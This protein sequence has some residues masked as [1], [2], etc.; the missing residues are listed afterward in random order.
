MVKDCLEKQ[1][2]KNL[3]HYKDLVPIPPLG[4]VD[5]LLTVTRC[6][7]Q[8]A[9]MNKFINDKA[10]TKKL[11]FGVS[12]CVKMHIGRNE[13]KPLCPN[14][15]LDN[16]KLSVQEDESSGRTY[17]KEEFSEQQLLSQKSEQRYLG[18]IVTTDGKCDKNIQNRRN[19]G[20]GIVNEIMNILE[21]TAF[22][23]YFFEVALMLRNSL[24]WSSG[25]LNCEAWVNISN[26][27][28]KSLEQVY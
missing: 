27:N 2:V 1:N 5:D 6:G 10:A 21:R 20:V 9:I 24:L 11:Q 13:I 22:G 4:L 28:M 26:K 15:Y 18:D 8:T 3:Y 17:L 12:K 14:L 19:R 7:F 25:L 23:K 16:W